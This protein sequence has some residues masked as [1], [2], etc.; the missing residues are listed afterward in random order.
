MEKDKNKENNNVKLENLNDEDLVVFI[1]ERDKEV[2]SFI[3]DRYQNKIW[4]YINRLINNPDESDDLTQQ[5]FVN[6]YINLYGFNKKRKFSSW[7]YRIAHNLAVNYLKKKK[8]SISLDQNKFIANTLFSEDDILKNFLKNEKIKE[9]SVLINNLPEKF[10]TPL[11]LKF[12]EEK[13]YQEISDILRIPKN[14][15]GTNI[16]KAKKVLKKELEKKYE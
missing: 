4:R 14:T 3:I 16:S 10:K 9:I 15:V 8:A 7:I 1:R 13:S 6:A 12:L 5:A 11:I 2:Y